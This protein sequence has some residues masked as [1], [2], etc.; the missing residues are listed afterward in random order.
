MDTHLIVTV[1]GIGEQKPGETVDDVVGAATTQFGKD[2]PNYEPV[3]VER[4]VIE[5]VEKRFNPEDRKASLFPVHLRRVKP[6]DPAR[7]TKQAV[8]AEV[9]WAD[10]SPAPQGAF[11][12]M[13]DLLK[14]ILGLGY[15]AMENAESNRRIFSI[16]L[17]HIF[18]WLFYGAVAPV[19][20][21]LL[22]GASLLLLD[23]TPI[24]TEFD[25]AYIPW[26]ILAHGVLSVAIGAYTRWGLATTYLVRI[27]GTGLLVVGLG[28]LGVLL[29]TLIDPTFGTKWCEDPQGNSVA[30]VDD[31]N[32]YARIG[33]GLL[34]VSW[35]VTVT[36]AVA[37]SLVALIGAVFGSPKTEFV[38]AHPEPAKDDGTPE[39]AEKT[40]TISDGVTGVR[41]IYPS[42]CAAMILFWMVITSSLWL[43]LVNISG[44]LSTSIAHGAE[45][46]STGADAHSVVSDS[47]LHGVLSD[48]I[49]TVLQT[50]SA[51]TG[52]LILLIVVAAI[53][54]VL[55]RIFKEG[56]YRRPEWLSRVILNPILQFFLLL[57][58]GVVAWALVAIN[59]NGCP[60]PDDG[61]PPSYPVFSFCWFREQNAI[62]TAILLALGLLIYRFSHL[63]SGG[64]GILRDIVTY[65]VQAH[66][67]W[68][69]DRP[70]R[71]KNFILR[72]QINARFKRTL[73]YSLEA[74]SP[75][76]V[77][78]ISH[79][80]GTVI[81]T[82]ML[83][84]GKPEDFDPTTDTRFDLHHLF[85]EAGSP[86]VRLI[87]MGSPVTHIYRRYFREFFQV[88]RAKM[89]IG[90]R[91][92][93]AVATEWFNIHRADDFVGTRIGEDLDRD[94]DDLAKNFDVRPKGHTG[95]FTDFHVW[96]RL[97]NNVG[98]RLFL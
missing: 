4:D 61:T 76:F 46:G 67:A 44:Q 30:V 65:S 49:K 42:I 20:A 91:G 23:L 97:Y 27:F 51:T 94:D 75:K 93:D 80:Q 66:C 55:R 52:S 96:D 41:A 98:F 53:I 82:Q 83:Q 22:I 59:L 63:I 25:R 18:T 16:G 11:W 70:S 36:L 33:L 74:F 84:D 90:E 21:A 77:T 2:D 9:Y 5:L 48:N 3:V 43:L 32:C 50:L 58:L 86:P 14:V 15:I 62:V 60:V 40:I 72:K 45:D 79:S 95:Y 39:Q 87:T 92:G 35:V 24:W 1:H 85:E 8:F 71:K 13:F 89:P 73:H 64:L 10:L 29:A 54:V 69:D 19:N 81:S 37:A 34:G 6:T 31:I 57:G 12:T 47:L 7:D 17:V 68:R 88:S 38:V 28:I 78:I 26:I 56:L